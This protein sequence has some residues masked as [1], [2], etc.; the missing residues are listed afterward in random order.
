MKRICHGCDLAAQKR[1]MYDCPF[2]RTPYPDNDADTL[3]MIQA[4]VEKKDPDAIHFLGRNTSM[5]SLDCKRIC[6]RQS[7]CGQRLQSLVR[8]KHSTTLELRITMGMGFKRTR[9]RLSSSTKRRPCKD[10]LRAGTIL[11]V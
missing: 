5:E 9:Q 2:C 10:M 6:E 3:A 7:N 8:L 4:R 11:A 1:G